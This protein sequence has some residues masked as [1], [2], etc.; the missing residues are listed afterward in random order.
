MVGGA[1]VDLPLPRGV[2]VGVDSELLPPAT[3]GTADGGTSIDG[4]DGTVGRVATAPAGVVDD[5]VG[6]A[7]AVAVAADEAAKREDQLDIG[8]FAQ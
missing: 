7:T 4:S 3:V 1:T 5:D 8:F 2:V 6:V